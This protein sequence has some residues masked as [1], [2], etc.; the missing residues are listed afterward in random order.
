M[1]SSLAA[2]HMAS[3][4]LASLKSLA[5]VPLGTIVWD[6]MSVFI[7]LFVGISVLGFFAARWRRASLDTLHQ[8]GLGGRTFGT[9]VTWF[10]LGGDLYT[11]YTFVAVPALVFGKGAIG[12]FAL[13]YT[14]VLY[15]LVYPFLSKLW[16]VGK[17]KGYITPADY[18]RDRFDSRALALLV[19]ITGIVATIPYIALQ[20]FGIEVVLSQMGVPVEVALWSA[21]AILALFTFVSGLR[22]PALIAVVKDTIIWITV[23]VAIFYIPIKLGG[24]G[25]IFDKVPAAKDTLTPPLF[26]SYTSL[27]LGSA[28]ALFLYPHSITSTF[29]ARTR[30]AVERNVSLL[31][32]YSF[33]LGLIAL[34][35]FMA[36]AAGISGTGPLGANA[37]FPQ[38]INQLFPGPFTGFAYAAIAIG[39]LVP[40]SVMSIAVANL[41][42]RNVWKE[43]LHR[44][45]SGNEET[46]VSQWV[47]AAVKAGAVAFILF[48]PT[49][50]AI[51]FQLAGGVWILQT[52][53]SVFLALYVRWLNR[54]AVMAGWAA[55][56]TWGTIMLVQEKFATSVHILG[57]LPDLA[58]PIYIG[59]SAF[60]LNL[61][62]CFVGTAVAKVFGEGPQPQVLSEADYFSQEEVAAGS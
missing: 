27:A 9:V 7:V 49:N 16:Q 14:I 54:W 45:A 37:A 3:S 46:R 19:A 44:T 38:L 28:M 1:T 51:N 6:Q 2:L 25:H 59:F 42:S 23:L 60:I 52:F 31:P 24:F 48:A 30:A 4:P 47:S 50:Y 40:A 15:P 33:L 62:V 12:L 13:P 41:F 20:M 53:P 32:A 17:N 29:S 35:G 26:S 34:F 56:I 11:A 8:W 57:F 22:A 10:L 58:A 55:G 36:I 21:F 39:A 43:F 5:L 18:V 61:V